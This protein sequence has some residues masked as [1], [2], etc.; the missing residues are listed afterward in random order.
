MVCFPEGNRNLKVWIVK[1]PLLPST[2]LSPHVTH[3][4]CCPADGQPRADCSDMTAQWWSAVAR[5][6]A[7]VIETV[8]W[9]SYLIQTIKLQQR[10]HMCKLFYITYLTPHTPHSNTRCH[11]FSKPDPTFPKIVICQKLLF[12]V[13]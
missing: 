10:C 2:F 5:A 8:I 11:L 7:I 4:S 3:T 12:T 6:P 9:L 1:S 13:A